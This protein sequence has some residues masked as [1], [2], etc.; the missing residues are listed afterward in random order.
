MIPGNTQIVQFLAARVFESRVMLADDIV[1][2]E[3]AM[4]N[5]AK[6]LLLGN[7]RVDI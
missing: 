1:I 6:T 2:S 3:N 4:D 7:G 5:V